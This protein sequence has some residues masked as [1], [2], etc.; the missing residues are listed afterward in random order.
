MNLNVNL[1]KWRIGPY[2]KNT[3]FFQLLAYIDARTA[4]NELDKRFGK[5]GWSTVKPEPVFENGKVVAFIH[6]ITVHPDTDAQVTRYDIGH[7]T[8]M[9]AHKGGVSDA[10]K[11]AAQTFGIGR[12]LYDQPMV[13]V[14]DK[15]FRPRPRFNETT[16]RWEI[17]APAY[18]VYPDDPEPEAEVDEAKEKVKELMKEMGLSKSEVEEINGAPLGPT[19]DNATLYAKLIARRTGGT[20]V[21]EG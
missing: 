8:N 7:T 14:P 1:I 3:G 6:G 19:T 13:F 16:G 11:R 4:M 21:D 15:D 2:N 18:V 5:E 20:V 17:D 12:E 9:E 10:F